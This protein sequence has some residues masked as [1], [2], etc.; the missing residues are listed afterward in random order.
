MPR[1]R[2]SA[3]APRGQSS[4]PRRTRV[5]VDKARKPHGQHQHYAE[6][7]YVF[8]E[9][10]LRAAIARSNARAIASMVDLRECNADARDLFRR[11]VAFLVRRGVH[12]GDI[13]CVFQHVTL[14]MRKHHYGAETCG[15]TPRVDPCT[16]IR[17]LCR[18]FKLNQTLLRRML[19]DDDVP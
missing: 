17:I 10:K 4:A 14:E 1:R 12:L 9:A 5:S 11:L 18:D 7:P 13:F 3:Q 2:A 16:A 6:K 8:D 15:C 19:D